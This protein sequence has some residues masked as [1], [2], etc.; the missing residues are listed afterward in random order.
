MGYEK[1]RR[2]SG[3]LVRPECE[4]FTLTEIFLG[5]IIAFLLQNIENKSET[6]SNFLLMRKTP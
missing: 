6:I 4:K 5:I 3:A 1:F 2:S